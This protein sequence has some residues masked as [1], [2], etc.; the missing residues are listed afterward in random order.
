MPWR[1]RVIRAG[2]LDPCLAELSV[3]HPQRPE[4]RFR[5]SRKAEPATKLGSPYVLALHMRMV[6]VLEHVAWDSEVFP[7]DEVLA[8]LARAAVSLEGSCNYIVPGCAVCIPS[9]AAGLSF[10]FVG[11]SSRTGTSCATSTTNS[12]KTTCTSNTVAEPTLKDTTVVT[13]LASRPR[14]NFGRRLGLLPPWLARRV[15]Q[16]WHSLAEMH[17]GSLQLRR[18]QQ[19]S[20][21][22]LGVPAR[23]NTELRCPSLFSRPSS[24]TPVLD[25]LSQ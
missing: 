22:A 12:T 11:A 13:S 10:F 14:L 8:A 17:S 18:A 16:F 7:Q 15:V 6:R 5:E 19:G 23:C 9:A 21:S 25:H 3:H 24:A 1:H 2:I 20:A 4:R